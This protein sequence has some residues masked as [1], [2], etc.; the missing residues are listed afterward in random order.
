M[1]VAKCHF[2]LIISDIRNILSDISI[3]E[4]QKN[5]NWNVFTFFDI[6]I[7]IIFFLM[8]VWTSALNKFMTISEKCR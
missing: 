1:Y 2:V 3:C 6:K 7:I 5:T 4:D 8:L